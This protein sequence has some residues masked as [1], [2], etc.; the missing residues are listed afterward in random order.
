MKR[1]G[2]GCVATAATCAATS[3]ANCTHSDQGKCILKSGTTCTYANGAD[4]I[5][6]GSCDDITGVGL[7]PAYCKG[8]SASGNTCSA[9]SELTSCIEKE[10]DCASYLT[11]FTGCL[12]GISEK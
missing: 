9:N 4:L 7:T 10:D 11:P 3:V 2:T 6:A 1:D 5:A 12:S 8:V